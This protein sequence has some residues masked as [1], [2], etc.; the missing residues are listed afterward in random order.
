MKKGKTIL[1]VCLLS[2]IL[3]GI[4]QVIDPVNNDKY[5]VEPLEY[6]ND[7]TV[8]INMKFNGFKPYT[9]DGSNYFNLVSLRTDRDNVIE[10]KRFNGKIFVNDEEV[11]QLKPH[12]LSVKNISKDN[13]I[14]I[15]FEKSNGEKTEMFIRTIPNKFPKYTVKG[16]SPY[17]GE[18]YLSTYAEVEGQYV[19]KI[20][21]SGEL[22]F[23]KETKGMPFNFTKVN[24]N[25]KIR[26]CYLEENLNDVAFEKVG[27][28]PCDLIVLDENYNQIKTIRAKGN[29]IVPENGPLE[30]HDYIYFDDNHYMVSSYVAYEEKYIPQEVYTGEEPVNVVAAV[31]QE[32]LDDKVIFQWQSIDFPSLYIDSKEHNDYGSLKRPIY[33]YCHLNSFT[34]DPSDNNLICSFRNLDAI[35]KIDRKSGVIL[36]KLGGKSDEFDLKKQS[37]GFSR[38]HYVRVIGDNTLLFFDNGNEKQQSSAVKVSYDVSNM[39]ITGFE[40]YKPF[41][42]FAPAMGSAQLISKDNDVILINYGNITDEKPLF[43]EMDFKNN[44]ELFSFSFEG[45]LSSYRVQKYK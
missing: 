29:G 8:F 38:Q 39:K 32:I 27:Y 37:Q 20:N 33:D 35:L 22:T 6:S 2:L 26:Y 14:K 16:Q 30:N 15:T 42:R 24:A 23:Y 25:N 7:K 36:W 45:G 28:K 19:F 21:N 17:E 5:L 11:K 43:Y 40:R 12:N 44:K 31:I 34:I 9:N 18:Y 10:F 4:F 3:V 1:V 41:K 13:N